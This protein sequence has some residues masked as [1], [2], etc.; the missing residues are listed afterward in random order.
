[1]IAVF[2][3][4]A[5]SVPLLRRLL[6]DGQLPTLADL[7]DRGRVLVLETPATHF[8]AGSYATLYSGLEIG[9]HGMYYSFQWSPAEQRVRWRGSFPSPELVWER[10]A[11]SGKRSLV[12]DPYETERPRNLNGVALSGWQF[13]NVMSLERWSTPTSAQTDLARRYGRPQRME[14]VFGRPT[15]GRLLALRRLLLDATDR[16]SKAALHF[17]PERFDLVWVNFLGAHLGG[18]MLWDLSQVDAETL[19]DRTRTTLERALTDIYIQID[20][21]IG[22][23]LATLP[24]DADVIVASPMGMAENMSRVDLLPGMLEAVLSTNGATRARGAESR[25]ERFLWQIRASIPTGA[26][27]KVAGALHGRLTREVTMR[28]SSLGVD[29]TKTPAFML[30]SDHFGQVRLNIRG[31]ERD[32]IVEPGDADAVSNEIREGLLTFRDPDGEPAVVAVDRVQDVIG[33][34]KPL[35]SLPDLVVRWSDRPS[36]H[37]HHVDSSRYG[38][39]RRPG[40][41]SGRS[42]AHTPEAWAVVVPGPSAHAATGS[43]RI[44]DIAPTVCSALGVEADG[45]PGTPLLERR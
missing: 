35:R 28:L 26:R 4:D 2:Q 6:A 9:D 3:F 18:H 31:R 43:P 32:G 29:W 24:G 19:D 21:G 25:T 11:R 7:R 44:V 27:A 45:L 12:V 38:E 34:E 42:G 16:A 22:R 41:G 10:L 33:P 15:V 39:V 20:K 13:V 5:V 37:V 23:I 36:A 8:P 40:S 30:P 1:V 17:L 14:E